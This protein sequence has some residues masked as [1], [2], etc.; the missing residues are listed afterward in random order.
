[1]NLTK[2][3]QISLSFGFA[4]RS[5]QKAGTLA[6]PNFALKRAERVGSLMQEKEVMWISGKPGRD[7]PERWLGVLISPESNAALLMKGELGS[8][9]SVPV[10]TG[11][12]EGGA[13]PPPV[14]RI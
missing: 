4:C 1:M 9:D 11:L 6:L 3:A 8:V 2:M 12:K 14:G 10:A 7:L 5:R 13:A